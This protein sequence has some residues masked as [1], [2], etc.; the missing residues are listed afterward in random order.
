M[1]PRLSYVIG[2]L[3]RV[4][5]RRLSAAVEPA[6]LTLPAYT[7]LSVLRAQDGLSNAR[8]ARRSL[9]TP[10]SMSEVLSLLVEQGYVRR[11][12][13]PGHG[14]V[15][16]IEL[17][18][19]GSRALERCDRAVDEVEREMLGDLGSDEA[20]DLRDALIRCERALEREGAERAGILKS[21]NEKD[22]GA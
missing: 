18:K 21:A 6:G 17:T 19:A 22:G 14:R 16:R 2:R 1:E 7:A 15:I 4:L 11:L 9:V 8:L 20:T 13:E 5:R 12:A 3:D 10:Q